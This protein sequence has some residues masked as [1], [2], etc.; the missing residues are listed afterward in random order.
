[1]NL[2]V[3]LSGI[4]Q[5]EGWPAI[6]N[7]A[8]DKGGLTKGGVTFTEYNAWLRKVGRPA[9]LPTEFV[10]ITETDA[11]EFMMA[12]IAGPLFQVS[13]IDI[14][15]FGVLFDWAETSGP[16]IPCRALQQLLRDD[17]ATLTIDGVY[18]HETDM[19]LR[20]VADAEFL[21]LLRRRLVD[22]RVLFYV[23]LALADRDVVTFRRDT[24]T[25]DLENL[26]GW[27]TR[28][29]TVS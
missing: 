11:R 23:K 12:D 7:R 10:Y 17:G 28:A 5:R 2:D 29:L 6:T 9:L 18:G 1:M 3:I 4:L 19:A 14:G 20:G 27:V 8:S 16:A 22:A 13:L 15:L 26:L 24:P 21:P 25:T